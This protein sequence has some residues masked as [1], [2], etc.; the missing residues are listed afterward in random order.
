M[1]DVHK[2]VKY[3]PLEDYVD[4]KDVYKVLDRG[5]CVAIAPY[6]KRVDKV[7]GSKAICILS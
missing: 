4:R 7:S 2:D 5:G 3:V 1:T 6:A